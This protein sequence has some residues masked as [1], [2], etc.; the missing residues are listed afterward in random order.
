MEYGGMVLGQHVHSS[1]SQVWATR[2]AFVEKWHSRTFRQMY[3][4]KVVLEDV[5][6]NTQRDTTV[7]MPL[8]GLEPARR[9]GYLIPSVGQ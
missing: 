3:H 5:G 8:L 4:S 2:F 7:A 9:I 6:P 1:L